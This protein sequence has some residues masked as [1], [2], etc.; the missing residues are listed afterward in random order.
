[1]MRSLF[2]L[3][4]YFSLCFCYAQNNTL[5]KVDQIAGTLGQDH[6]AP[7]YTIAI[8]KEGKT[9]YQ[10][11]VG[12]ANLEDKIANSDSSLFNLAS[13]TKQFTAACVW[14]LIRDQK[15]SLDDDIRTYIPEFPSYGKPIRIRHLLNHTSGIRNYHTLMDLSGFDYDRK[16]YDNNDILALAC[17]QKGL[18]NVPGEKVI[19]GNTP[20]NLLAIMIERISGQNLN[21]YAQEHLFKPLGMYHSIYD[22]DSQT[23][24][25]NRSAGYGQDAQG[26]FMLFPKNQNSYGA[27]SAAATSGDMVIWSDIINGRN[28]KYAALTTFLRTREA[29]ASGDTADYARGLM[30]D[31]YKGYQTV[32]HSGYS[33][34]G[35][36][37]MLSVPELKLSIIIL[38]NNEQI[39]P[40]PVSYKILDVLLSQYPERKSTKKKQSNFKPDPAFVKTLCGYYQEAYSDME[41]KL[42]FENDTLRSMGTG[43]KQAISLIADSKYVF[44]RENNESIIYT[45]SP[46]KDA[47]PRLII[48][49]GGAPFYFEREPSREPESFNARYYT[50]KYYSPELLVTYEFS[51]VKNT[52]QLSYPGHQN[53]ALKALGDNRFGNGQRVLYRF[54]W[55]D[56]NHNYDLLLSAEGTVKEIAFK[57]IGRD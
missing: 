9:I 44:H 1:M 45:F 54:V 56:M 48:S 2:F 22:V 5:S 10:K 40:G 17:R 26:H 52:L 8:V 25:P 55:N 37:Q 50:G 57:K 13:I 14:T 15:L 42:F 49:F 46:Q 23:F 41:M 16:Y 29:L 4:S 21:I 32:H 11:S 19:Y 27:G 20:Y 38:T 43:A 24:I 51:E 34:G 7:G 36:T 39:N 3:L 28:K 30:V 6:N 12:L 35:Q 33:S 31:K 53:I 18:N 47:E